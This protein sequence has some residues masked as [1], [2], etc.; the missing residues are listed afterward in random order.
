M[1][2]WFLQLNFFSR[3]LSSPLAFEDIAAAAADLRD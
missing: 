2:H 1:P 3:L